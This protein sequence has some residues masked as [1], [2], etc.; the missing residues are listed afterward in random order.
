MGSAVTNRFL[1]KR[2]EFITLLGGAAAAWPLAARAQQDRVKRVGVLMGS[3]ENNPE[4]QARLAGFLQGL[5]R[6]GWSEGRNIR[7]DYR[8]GLAGLQMQALAK[9]LVTLQPDVILAHS[10]PAAVA[11]H[12]KTSTIPVVFAS[13]GNPIGFGLIASLARPGGNFTGLTTYEASIA[14]KWL[15]MLKEIAPSINRTALVG[16]PKTTNFDYYQRAIEA[17]ARSFAIELVPTPVEEA[18]DVERGIGS[19]A[20]VSGGGLVVFP[21]PTTTANSA[22]IIAQAA[23]HRLPAVYPIRF[24]VSMG[25]LM[26]YGSDRVDELRQAASYVDRILRGASPADLPVQTPIKFETAINLKTARALGLAVPDK[27]LVAADEVI[28]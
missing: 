12:R 13:I 28:E 26:S 11:L 22:T 15:A 7:I 9:E 1:Y 20:R 27:L 23:R 18:A 21:D 5:E 6:L 14:G 17:A 8:F 2:R 10:T 24:F 4:V 19:F 25:G 3:P 16:D